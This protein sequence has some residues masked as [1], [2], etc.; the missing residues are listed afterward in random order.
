MSTG[1]IE[2]VLSNLIRQATSGLGQLDEELD[3][4]KWVARQFLAWWQSRG[5]EQPLADARL[6]TQRIR[7]ELERLGGWNNS[8]F[9]EA[10]HELIHL[11][12]AL[13]E[14]RGTLGLT[15]DDSDVP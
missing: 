3:P 9:G 14:I 2:Q 5:V 6:A 13:A 11:S 8:Q 15:I 10:M 4:S 1:D 12:D 7:A